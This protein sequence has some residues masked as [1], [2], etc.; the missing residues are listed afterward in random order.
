M[1]SFADV[2]FSSKQDNYAV[3]VLGSNIDGYIRT[4]LAVILEHIYLSPL[5]DHLPNPLLECSRICNQFVFQVKHSD[6]RDV[7]VGRIRTA[8]NKV[9]HGGRRGRST[10]YKWRGDYNEVIQ[11]CVY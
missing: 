1:S 7:S 6:L 9:A 3:A 8:G 5:A 2:G 11:M 4:N 10:G